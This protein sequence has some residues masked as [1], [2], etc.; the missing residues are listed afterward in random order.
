MKQ[1]SV[2]DAQ[3]AVAEATEQV[4][5]QGDAVIED[6]LWEASEAALDGQPKNY[7][8]DII[9]GKAEGAYKPKGGWRVR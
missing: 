2:E 4:I 5:Q 8:A 1:R 6:K 3:A 9:S 7:L